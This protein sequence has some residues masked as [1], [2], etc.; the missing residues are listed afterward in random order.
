[1][2]VLSPPSSQHRFRSAPYDTSLHSPHLHH[3]SLR[4]LVLFVAV[5]VVF[6]AL[7]H[8]SAPLQWLAPMMSMVRT[9]PVSIRYRFPPVV[10]S[11]ALGD[12][13]LATCVDSS[14]VPFCVTH[15][16]IRFL[17]PCLVR[18]LPHSSVTVPCRLPLQGR[19]HWRCRCRV[20]QPYRNHF[21]LVPN[22]HSFHACPAKLSMYSDR[23]VQSFFASQSLLYL[24]FFLAPFSLRRVI[25]TITF[26]FVLLLF[27]VLCT[28]SSS[29]LPSTI[30]RPPFIYRPS[31]C[32]FIVLPA[33][34]RT[35]SALFRFRLHHCG[36]QL[37]A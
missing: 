30:S 8:H 18:R 20:R 33:A 4:L 2:P 17:F 19:A 7:R 28:S 32:A 11:L 24:A 35:H 10:V 15:L 29:F 23:C 27:N 1:M 25:I 3:P 34:F 5:A 31:T 37:I 12:S 26:R 6:T 13:H 22:V 21:S 9:N 14:S 36:H 16:C